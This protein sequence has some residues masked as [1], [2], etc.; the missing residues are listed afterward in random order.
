MIDNFEIQSL[1]QAYFDAYSANDAD[2]CAANFTVDARIHT[3]FAPPIR[4]RT[5][6]R[7]AH[8]RWFEEG[9]ENKT[10]AL[11]YARTEGGAGASLIS[12]SAN[13]PARGG[14][15]SKSTGHSLCALERDND[16]QWMVKILSMT[17]EDT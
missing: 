1:F 2:G 9:E 4:G 8:S 17:L 15:F 12:F 14:G 7:D 11:N 13:V 10:W 3:S 5:A 16:E 6:I